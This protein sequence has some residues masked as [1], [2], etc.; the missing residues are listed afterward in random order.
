MN[1]L[2]LLVITPFYKP[3][4]VYGGPVRSIPALC[5]ALALLGVD[6]TV[7]TTNANGK[8][9]LDAHS[10]RSYDVNGV[11]VHYF[12][13]IG[14]GN[15]FFSRELARACY[16]TASSFDLMYV[17]SIWGYPFIPACRAAIRQQVPFV[18]TTRG[19]FIRWTWEGKYLKKLAYHRLVE[20]SLLNQAAALHYTTSLEVEESRWMGLNMPYFVVPNPVNIEEFGQ[21]PEAGGFRDK[22]GLDSQA[23]IILFLGRVEAF[24]G[25]DLTLQAFAKVIN[26]FP[27]TRLVLAGPEED[28]YLQ[29]ITEMAI[30][31][32]IYERLIIAG[33]L[34]PSQRLEAIADSDIFVL[35]SYSENFGVAV[36]EA[37]AGGL[38]VLISDHVGIANDVKDN[39]AGIVVSL[40]H[41][42]LA[43]GMAQL[44]L[45]D[46]QRK[47][48][49]CNGKQAAQNY[50]PQNVAE[51]ILAEFEG[52]LKNKS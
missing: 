47:R 18:V 16:D 42:A 49:G 3:A 21:M 12:K 24:K 31:L 37:M 13:R 38:P 30:S 34:N 36:V 11:Q 9:N 19:S 25:I 2:R 44:L 33:F 26:Q 41:E 35:A 8:T 48:M 10:D 22:Y 45:S 52:I 17:S 40:N 27:E 15:Y 6:V 23:K 51:T 1:K 32:K 39:D 5:E 50:R 4:F 7:Y 20:R 46:E 29:T 14:Q 28:G 43:E